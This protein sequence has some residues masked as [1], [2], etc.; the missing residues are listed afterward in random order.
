MLLS[1]NFYVNAQIFENVRY[2]QQDTD[3]NL[4]NLLNAEANNDTKYDFI[5]FR[6][7]SYYYIDKN[8]LNVTFWIK[9][10]NALTSVNPLKGNITY[11]I[12]INSDPQSNTGI[13]GVD[14]D[15]QLKLDSNKKSAKKELKEISID[16][17]TKTIR[18]HK[19]NYTELI[20]KEKNYINLNLNLPDIHF[21]DAF[22]VLFYAIFDPLKDEDNDS[23]ESD[24]CKLLDHLKWIDIPP[25]GVTIDWK[26]RS[27]NL[28]QGSDEQLI[29]IADSQSTSD[30]QIEFYFQD[31]PKD[32]TIK[33]NNSTNPSGTKLKLPSYER[34]FVEAIIKTNESTNPR[35][36][37]LK[38]IAEISIPEKKISYFSR[39]YG[40]D[41]GVNDKHNEFSIKN[42]GLKLRDFIPMEINQ[43]NF[44]ETTLDK[45]SKR[46]QTLALIVGSIVAI[47]TPLTYLKRSLIKEALKKIKSN[48]K[49]NI[50]KSSNDREDAQNNIRKK[51]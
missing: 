4:L 29:I 36:L 51:I 48:R 16:G 49:R 5:N 24:S 13:D 34:G 23:C 6:S 15:L 3:L 28:T 7:A 38:L 18:S 32:I 1:N 44:L 19:E 8:F 25:P 33:F 27:I 42:S 26:P 14:Y 20:Q 46:L 30:A 12:L 9:S 45:Y 31:P 10:F 39:V 21:P 35:T 43:Y 17:D 2:I 11:G 40:N 22:K 41:I 50:K 37:F 47:L